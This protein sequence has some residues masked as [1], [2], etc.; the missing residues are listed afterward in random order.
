MASA[1]SI[2]AAGSKS[3]GASP[4]TT[5][6]G[7]SRRPSRDSPCAHGWAASAGSRH[8][9]AGRAPGGAQGRE[10]ARPEPGAEPAPCPEMEIA[11]FQPLHVLQVED[12][13][14]D[15]LL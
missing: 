4:P 11:E 7:C 10:V 9:A 14:D 1:A 15:A 13:E 3:V 6:A 8:S 12:A 5:S 2:S